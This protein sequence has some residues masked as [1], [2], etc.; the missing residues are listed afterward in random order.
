[1]APDRGREV[2][3]RRIARVG[4]VA[5]ALLA[6]AAATAGC[7]ARTE[8][9][10]AATVRTVTV[11]A[12]PPNAGEAPLYAAI[13]GGHFAEAGLNVRLVESANP[14]QSLGAVGAGRADL[15]VSSEPALLEARDRGLPVVSVGAL[16]NG[17]LSAAIWLPGGAVRTPADFLRGPIGTL[18]LD[19]QRAFADTMVRHAGGH[20]QPTSIRDISSDVAG[21]L[22]HKDVIAAVGAYSND[23]GVRLALAGKQPQVATVD[24][25]GVPTFDEFV[26]VAR[27]GALG[28]NGDLIRSFIGSLVRGARDLRLGSAQPDASTLAAAQPA[29]GQKAAAVAL[30][31]TAPLLVPAGGQ[32]YGYQDAAFW[33]SFAAWMRGAG[34]LSGPR[35]SAGAFTNAYLPGEGLK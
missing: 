10:S 4:G 9:V 22:T 23:Q 11:A 12:L 31:Q 19:Y 35:G 17:P 8:R 30:K 14:L 26:L 34:L 28:T 27:A 24:R 3:A 6:A 16:V 13:R 21:A 18:G 15:A 29:A 1:M 2:S 20:G 32:V 25:Y 7:G 33:K 5:A